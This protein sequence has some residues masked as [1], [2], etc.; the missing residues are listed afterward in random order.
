MLAENANANAQVMIHFDHSKGGKG[1]VRVSV[2]PVR[3]V[4]PSFVYRCMWFW[5]Q[6]YNRLGVDYTAVLCISMWVC[7]QQ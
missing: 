7:K 1:R 5:V 6:G 2:T 4:T 3:V